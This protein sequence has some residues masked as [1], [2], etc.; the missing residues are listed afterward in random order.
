VKYDFAAA[1]YGL[2]VYRAITEPVRIHVIGLLTDPATQ[3]LLAA[4]WRGDLFHRVVAPM[5]PERDASAI[6]AQGFAT[7]GLPIAYVCL[8]DRCLAPARTP[9]ELAERIVTLA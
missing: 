2:A 4:A 7:D 1:P 5:D 8:G 9:E 6:R 3:R